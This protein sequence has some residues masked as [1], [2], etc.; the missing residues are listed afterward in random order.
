[1]A[2]NKNTVDAAANLSIRL[3]KSLNGCGKKQTAVAL[4]LGLRKPGHVTVQ[5]DNA[6]TNG[7]I[8]KISHL[9][10]VTKL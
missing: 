5:P 7:K 9:V 8:A 4:S 2:E 10:V 1:M 6:A 3:A